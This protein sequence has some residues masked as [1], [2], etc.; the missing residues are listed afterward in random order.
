MPYVKNDVK[1][2]LSLII[3]FSS[4]AEN[5]EAQLVCF[6]ECYL[7]GYELNENTKNI[8]IDLKSNEFEEI[9]A[10]LSHLKPFV[11]F[12][13]VEK[14]GRE[15]FNTA[16][17]IHNGNLI[18]KYRK[19]NLVGAENNIFTA[20]DDFPVFEIGQIKLGINICYDTNFPAASR[21]IANQGA[22]LL[23]CPCNNLL[24]ND[25]AK[26]WKN[27]HSPARISR[28]NENGMWLVSSDIA[29]K[30]N[31]KISYGPTTFICPDKGVVK[32]LPLMEPNILVYKIN[33]D[34][35]N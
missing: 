5:Q 10:K 13:M 24:P 6:P 30:T 26:K 16:V 9:L 29:G 11:I 34:V 4:R 35:K 23:I 8:A 22:E 3:D 33:F 25:I 15:I 18:G 7:Q 12:G 31:D 21:A 28:S 14:E 1:K 19:T 2:S 32:Q 20:G 27:E 17:V